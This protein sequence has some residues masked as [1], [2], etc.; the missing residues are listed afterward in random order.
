AKVEPVQ[1]EIDHFRTA[2][3]PRRQA[4]VVQDQQIGVL[5]RRPGVVIGRG[6]KGDTGGGL[7]PAVAIQFECALLAVRHERLIDMP[8]G[9][10]QVLRWPSRACS[11][12]HHVWPSIRTASE[13]GMWIPQCSQ[14][15]M[16]SA[17]LISAAIDRKSTRLNS[18]HVKISYA[19]F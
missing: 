11:C 7:Q 15:T 13:R 2:K 12:P 8:I 18:S 10:R 6:R 1:E 14:R 19:V 4:D 17:S 5:S 3:A 9:P 16:A